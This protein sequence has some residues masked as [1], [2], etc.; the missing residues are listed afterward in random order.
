MNILVTGGSGYI[1]S[2]LV[3]YLLKQNHKIRVFETQIFGNPIAHLASNR[4]EFIEGDI[5]DLKSITR[6]TKGIQTVIHLAG[7]VTD[8][9]VDMNP[10]FGHEVNVGGTENV[11]RA[12]TT[13]SVPR[14]VYA[15]SSSIYGEAAEGKTPPTEWVSPKPKTIYAKQKLEGEEI[16]LEYGTRDGSRFS[17]AVRQATAMGPAP[18]MR[19]DTVVN[20]FSKQAY[21]DKLITPYGGSQFRSNV[22]I[23]DVARFYEMLATVDGWRVNNRAW[24][25]TDENLMVKEIAHR[26]HDAAKDRDIDVKVEIQDIEDSRSYRLDG[27][28]AT[29]DLSFFT[30]VGIYGAAMRNFDYFQKSK[31]DPTDDIYYNNRRM[32]DVVKGV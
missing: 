2:A 6:A 20:I 12:C 16:V 13:N 21:F 32:A 28:K 9:L 7:V 26:V 10:D 14:I 31:L 23:H 3:E 4:C 18:R 25:L 11:V 1:G 17:T 27:S 24:N 19:L 22:F 15:S 5:R 29:Q 30:S 8:E